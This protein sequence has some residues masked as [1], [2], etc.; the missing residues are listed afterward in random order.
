[1]AAA[2][3]LRQFGLGNLRLEAF[4]RAEPV[5]PGQVRVAI[6]TVSLNYRDLLVIRGTYCPG[7]QLPLIPL[8]DAAGCVTEVGDGVDGLQP[9][10]R[11]VTHT[12]PDSVE[13]PWFPTIRLTTY[14]GPAHGRMVS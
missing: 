14:G 8:S 13:G 7:L 10:D 1:M 5:G 6:R 9:G 4:Q 3:V 11:V 2:A 12:V